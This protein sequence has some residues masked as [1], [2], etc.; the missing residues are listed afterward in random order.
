MLNECSFVGCF[1]PF[2]V[3]KKE[4]GDGVRNLPNTKFLTYLRKH[5]FVAG[6]SSCEE[7]TLQFVA[8]WL[9]AGR[10]HRVGLVGLGTPKNMRKKFYP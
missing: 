8:T 5:S 4:E 7:F 9:G 2:S 3:Q 6:G 1:A 10:T